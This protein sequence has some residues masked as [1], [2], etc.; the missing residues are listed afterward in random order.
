MKKWKPL[1]APTQQGLQQVREDF[2]KRFGY[3]APDLRQVE[4]HFGN[5]RP[6][7]LVVVVDY[8]GKPL[9]AY[10]AIGDSVHYMDL[11]RVEPLQ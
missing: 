3:E 9:A 5:D 6:I 2:R 11:K 4:G 8:K 1:P 7:P 10:T